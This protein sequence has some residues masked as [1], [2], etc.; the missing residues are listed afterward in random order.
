MGKI[1][2][3]RPR[4]NYLAEKTETP[5]EKLRK[6]LEE[7]RSERHRRDRALIRSTGVVRPA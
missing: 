3:T 7:V 4:E 1:K 5:E 2:L 6:A